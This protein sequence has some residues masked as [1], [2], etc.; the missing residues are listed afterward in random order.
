MLPSLDLSP[1]GGQKDPYA[2]LNAALARIR[3]KAVNTYHTQA[4]YVSIGGDKLYWGTE[5]IDLPGTVVDCSVNRVSLA[6]FSQQF[7]FRVYRDGIVD[8]VRI[9]LEDKSV[10]ATDSIDGVFRPAGEKG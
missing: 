9:E 8:E 7:P 6:V 1:S 10:L 3:D 4:V 5:E 2:D